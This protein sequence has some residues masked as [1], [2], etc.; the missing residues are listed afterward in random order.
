MTL[1]GPRRL[2]ELF[3]VHGVRPDKALGQNFVIEPN[4]IRKIVDTAGVG[5]TDRVCEIGA[6]GGSLT[7]ELAARCRH[8]TAIEFDRR[9]LPVL[10][11]VLGGVP[12]VDVIAADA[13]TFD[14]TSLGEVKIV[15]NLPYNI[16]ATLV[17]RV[18]ETA[19]QI[20][21]LTVMT[22]REVGERLAGGPGSKTY[23]AVSVL[24]G[25]WAEARIVG[26]VPRTAF[27]PVPNVD[28]VLVKLRRREPFGVAQPRFYSVV[29][30]AFAQRR[31]TLRNTLRD[32]EP[33]IESILRSCGVDPGA[34]AEQL[35]PPVFADIARAL[36]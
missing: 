14:L 34:R 21:E 9:L 2:R 7:L 27:W 16:A 22:Q 30:A 26:S 5:E 23:G 20:P 15:A 29:K 11:E 19:P 1:L 33:D 25:Y 3:D 17:L 10:D 18:L 4:T 13:L 28:S 24:V 32:L 31:K 8:V 12:N 6:G 36:P 35:E